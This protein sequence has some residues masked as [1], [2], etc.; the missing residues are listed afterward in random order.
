MNTPYK[1]LIVKPDGA[2]TGWGDDVKN[3]LRTG[4]TESAIT[5]AST[6]IDAASIV[7]AQSILDDCALSYLRVSALAN[8]ADWDSIIQGKKVAY[9]SLGKPAEDI[10]TELIHDKLEQLERES[11][12]KKVD[13]LFILCPPPRNYSPIDNYAFD[14]D[15]LEE[16]DER[17][18]GIIHRNGMTESLTNIEDDL[19]FISKTANFLMG[20]VNQKY[21]VRLNPLLLLNLPALPASP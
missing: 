2:E 18:H 4:M 7:F 16:I 1:K 9:S 17:R 5:N 15:R 14:R 19:E 11:L 6:A 20:L 10:R 3:M 21:D 13:L 12:L 8:P